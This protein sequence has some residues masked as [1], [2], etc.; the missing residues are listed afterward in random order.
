[1]FKVLEILTNKI[2]KILRPT[3][4]NYGNVVRTQVITYVRCYRTGWKKVVDF[5][6]GL[7][8]KHYKSAGF[9]RYFEERVEFNQ[10]DKEGYFRLVCNDGVNITRWIWRTTNGLS[11]L[12][13]KLC[14]KQ[15]R[16]HRLQRS[17][18]G[19]SCVPFQA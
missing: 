18:Q 1:M 7:W 19:K 13:T 8:R 14:V 4:N 9:Q 15:G 10:S 12:E 2:N 5:P 6:W 3:C 16:G 11:G 17:Y